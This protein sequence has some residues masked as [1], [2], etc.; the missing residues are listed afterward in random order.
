MIV[1]FT[2]FGPTG[3]YTGQMIAALGKIAPHVPVID[4]LCD[5]PAFD[6]RASAY[7]LAALIRDFPDESVFLGIVDPGVGIGLVDGVAQAARAE[8]QIVG[9]RK[10][11]CRSRIG[12]Q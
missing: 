12:Q 3:P 4:L 2:D 5:A 11:G 1:L 8:I 6:A 10:Y 7:L 9:H